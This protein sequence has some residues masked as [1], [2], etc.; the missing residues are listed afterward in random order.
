MFRNY[1]KIKESFTTKKFKPRSNSGSFT[2]PQLASLYNF[3]TGF[4]GTGQTIGIIELGGGYNLSDITTYLRSLNIDKNPNIIDV[5]VNNAVNNPLDTSGAN[6]EVVLDIEIVASIVP[7]ATIRVY[8]A[9]NSYQ[10]FYNA[11]N[12]AVI[13]NCNIITISWGAPEVSW[14]SNQLNAY[15]TLFQTASANNISIFCA[16]GD[17]GSTDGA[18]GNNVDFPSSSPYVVACGGTS[19]STSNNTILSETVWNNNSDT[20]STGG[21]VSSFFSKPNYQNNIEFMNQYNKRGVPDVS[22]NADPNTGY[23]IYLQGQTIQIGGTSAVS[24]LW[25]ALTAIVNQKNSNVIGFL[26]PKIYSSDPN[27]FSDIT[28]GNNGAFTARIGYDLCTGLG[29]PCSALFTYLSSQPYPPT[30]SFNSNLES[31]FIPLPIQ[32]T[33]TSSNSPT[34]WNWNFGDG[35]SNSTLKNPTHIYKKVGSFV[36]TLTAIN[37][38]GSNSYQKTITA[39]SRNVLPPSSVFNG[40]SVNFRDYSTNSPTSW[41]WNFGDGTSS[42]LQNPTHVYSKAGT[43]YVRL[44]VTNSA[45]TSSSQQIMTLH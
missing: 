13:D 45:G 11:I 15:N 29:T 36:V 16:A 23:L 26:Q 33:D 32:F 24:P 30:A 17:N 37:N 6:Y 18:V 19:L 4:D 39:S 42:S 27:T 5:S 35:T 2:P 43:Y 41:N 40:L 34:S 7:G 14:S 20:S 25:A 3:P 38:N 10:G 9:P 28:V 44:I 31:G 8:F 12:Q 21:G 22:G 1:Y